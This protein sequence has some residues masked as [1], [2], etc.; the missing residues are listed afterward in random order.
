MNNIAMYFV[1][2]VIFKINL[3][4]HIQFYP[5]FLESHLFIHN[6]GWVA[7]EAD[8]EIRNDTIGRYIW[9]GR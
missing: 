7:Q 1:L 6:L 8:P 2:Y 3:P 9:G 5:V 4:M